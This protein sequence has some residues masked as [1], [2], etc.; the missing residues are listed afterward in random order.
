[1]VLPSWLAAVF[2]LALFATVMS[3]LD[4]YLFL[5]AATVGHDLAIEKPPPDAERRR[6]RWGLALSALL[7]SVGA[8]GEQARILLALAFVLAG[9]VSDRAATAPDSTGPG[10]TAPVSFSFRITVAS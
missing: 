1:M 3:T 4:S 9:A 2:T 10:F 7:A 8:G 6:T 5:S